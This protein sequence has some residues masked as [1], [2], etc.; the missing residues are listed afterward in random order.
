MIAERI[1]VARKK[2]L[3]RLDDF[4]GKAINGKGQVCF[5]TG[6]AGSGKTALMT[7]FT[8]RAQEKYK[9]LLVAVGQSDAQTGIGDPY[10]PFREILGQLTGDVGGQLARGTITEGNA[11][12]LMDFIK[13]SCR[14]IVDVGPDLI[15]IFVPAAGLLTRVGAFIAD[16]AGI[17]ERI[18]EQSEERTIPDS[19]GLEQSHIF[20]QYTNVLITLA[21][22]KPLILVLDDL[23]WADSASI[24]LL[25]RL[26]R[27]IGDCRILVVGSYRPEEVALQRAGERHPLEKVLA[28]FKRYYGDI[29][30]HLDQIGEIERATFVDAYLKTEPN[31]LSEEFCRALYQHTGGHAL[32][33]IELLRDLQYRG[34]IVKDS[35]GYWVEGPELEWSVLPARVEG[36]IEE[37]IGRLGEELREALTVAST[38]GEDFTAEVVAR[39]QSLDVRRFVRNLS[40]ELE[41]KHRLVIAQG[42]RRM[43]S[44]NLSL[45]RFQHNLFQR[46]LYNQLDEAERA[47]L[48]GDVGSVLEELYGDQVDEIAVQ[49]ARHFQEA[50]NS[51]KARLYLQRAGELAAMRYAN[52][53]A[54]MYLSQALEMNPEQEILDRFEILISRE[55][56]YHLQGNREA[57]RAD[58]DSL[59]SLAEGLDDCDQAE[60]LLQEAKF[61]E[62]VG[63][64]QAGYET[65]EKAIPLAQSC[66]DQQR[67]AAGFQLMGLLQIRAFEHEAAKTSLNEAL[68]LSRDI[69]DGHLEAIVLHTIGILF[70]N[71]SE[72]GEAKKYYQRSLDIAR[73]RGDLIRQSSTLNNLGLLSQKEG[74]PARAEAYYKQSLAIDQKVGDRKG[75][76]VVLQNI[77]II[78]AK[79]GEYAKTR[80][81]FD[82]ALQISREVDD[83]LAEGIILG[84][85]GFASAE[86]GDYHAARAYFEQSVNLTK[87][88]GNKH[89]ECTALRNLG[90][91]YSDMGEFDNAK[92]LYDRA[93]VVAREISEPELESYI[94]SSLGDYYC[95]IGDYSKGLNYNEQSLEIKRK[96]GN[97]DAEGDSLN[98]LG[99]TYDQLGQFAKA[100][101]TLEESKNLNRET[102]DRTGECLS[103]VFLGLVLHHLDQKDD[104]M[105]YGLESLEVSQSLG[106]RGLQALALTM[107]GHAYLSA[108][109][110]SEAESAYRGSMA[111]QRELGQE[112]LVVEPQAGLARVYLAQDNISRAMSQVENLY[113][114]LMESPPYG[115]LEPMRIYLTCYRVLREA[116]DQRTRQVLELAHQE[117][118]ERSEK[119]EDLELREL[120]LE[121]IE[122]NQ[123]IMREFVKHKG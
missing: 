50:G 95:D 47:Y 4:L 64:Y 49:L 54:V 14:A 97:R 40:G 85:L 27:R 6:E 55:R 110:L 118:Q 35:D 78:Y 122:V 104:A 41:K 73:Q 26:G 38:E 71:M 19:S 1:F 69:G 67:E 13:F 75:V 115:T 81:Y 107:L 121:N 66:G 36:V 100:I 28:E 34:D 70:D 59:N 9:G 42:L 58:L 39:V 68:Q 53:E 112:H 21:A 92:I 5:V 105:G 12:R 11:N 93:L 98:S 80:E 23:Q 44:Q 88:I 3:E 102:G 57:Q 77:G 37:R 62:S 32:F 60:V 61:F 96:I 90:D 7:E 2:E 114:F 25:F 94:L 30:I 43:D 120:Y 82:Q 79:Q 63:E 22:Q 72:Y 86:Q 56:I 51:V 89:S 83:R 84:N 48:H 29:Y 8:R 113:Q 101:D 17:L 108:V 24:A 46:Y 10:L 52:E 111:I 20:E 31:R 103:M 116:Q 76:G 99:L 123:E 18:S 119:I 16:E 117:L 91:V 45:Y 65:I 106:N 87:E 74:D 33:T 109:R 15:G